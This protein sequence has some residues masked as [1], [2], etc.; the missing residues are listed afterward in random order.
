ML[1]GQ[2]ICTALLHTAVAANEYTNWGCTSS[3]P[4][5]APQSIARPLSAGF[6]KDLQWPSPAVRCTPELQ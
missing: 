6:P 2:P 5:S 3:S 4:F 1:L